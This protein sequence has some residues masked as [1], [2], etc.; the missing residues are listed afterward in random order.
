[1]HKSNAVTAPVPTGRVLR[2][3]F[4]TLFIDLIGFSIIFPLFPSMLV[5]YRETEGA[6]GLFG[7]FYGLLLRLS[8][9]AGPPDREWGSIVLFGGLLGS[10]YSLLQ[11]LCAPLFGAISDR[12]GRKP[13]LL[14][15]MTGIFISYVLWFFAGNFALLVFS[16]FIGGIMSANIS[17]ATAIVADITDEKTRSRGMAIIGIAFG[18]GFILGPAIGGFSSLLKLHELLPALVPFGVN[19]YSAPA[20]IALLLS[21]INI[22]QVAS[23]LPETRPEHAREAA[24]STQRSVNPFVL[25]HAESYPGVTRTNWTYF[26]FM[27]AFS[28]MEFSL[29]F[30]AVDRLNYTPKENTYIFLFVGVVLAAVQGSYV[31]RFSHRVGNKRMSIQGLALVL[32]GFALIGG[33]G[34]AQNSLLLYAGLFFLA[35]GAAQATPCLTALVSMYTPA[36]DQGRTV[37]V[38][39]SLGA[40]ARALGPL[41]ASLMYWRV[42]ADVAYYLGAASIILPLALALGLPPLPLRAQPVTGRTQGG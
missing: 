17:T 18:L 35:A 9:L 21:L 25:L 29:T 11:F 24:L 34:H 14:V 2:I 26:L 33:A 8:E 22:V 5:Y 32:P 19:P 31:Q 23:R 28:G 42:G 7:Y 20:G 10:I 6:G 16:R 30:L 39:R 12:I 40:L 37:G 38:F 13:V 4:L 15:S 1:M 36:H 41:V 3:I 27:L